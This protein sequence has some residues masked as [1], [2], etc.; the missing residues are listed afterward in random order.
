M[1]RIFALGGGEIGRQ[2]VMPDGS[3]KQ[4]PVETLSIDTEIIKTTGK[5][6]PILLFIGTASNESDSYSK[7]VLDH[8]G[9]RLGCTITELK[10]LNELPRKE[11]I[12]QKI[13]DADIIYVGGGDT[14]LMLDTWKKHGVDKMLVDAWKSG[15]ILSGLSAGAICWFDY[16]DN[17]EY[18]DGDMAKLDVLPGLGLI[19]GF[20]G[21]HWDTM[22]DEYKEAV[23]K[24][25]ARKKIKGWAID[26]SAAILENNGK[27][28]ILSG[29]AGRIARQ[30]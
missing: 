14:K 20:A 24:L 25:L 10:L 26:N 15:K 22:S 16:Y 8:F 27:I 30:I 2:K 5:T 23:A 13:N 19:S 6:N 18:I 1:T 29:M 9:G 7:A 12:T 3:V 17:E 28:S 21:V 11:Q 4:Y